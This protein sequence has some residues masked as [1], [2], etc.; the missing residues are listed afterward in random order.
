M[1][2]KEFVRNFSQLFGKPGSTR[3]QL[4][5]GSLGIAGVRFSNTLLAFLASVILAR[6]LGANDFGVYSFV[7]ALIMLLCVPI[8]QG[9]AKLIIR[10]TAT[11]DSNKNWNL[12]RGLWQWSTYTNL[13]Y[14]ILISIFILTFVWFL[15]NQINEK[16]T[17]TIMIALLLVPFINQISLK[18][19]ALM[20]LRKVAIGPFPDSVL[21]PGL[22]IFLILFVITILPHAELT[23]S[24]A[25]G[26]H[27]IAAS[28]A[29]VASAAILYRL[30][31]QPLVSHPKPVFKTNIWAK[32]AL[33]LALIAGLQVIN[34]CADII[35]LGLLR[36]SEEVGI[37]RVVAQSGLLITFVMQTIGMVAGPYIA[38]FYSQKDHHNLQKIITICTR[39]IFVIS[40]PIALVLSIWGSQVLG[41]LFGEGYIRGHTALIILST[42]LLLFNIIGPVGLLL[43]MTG[44][45]KQA[46]IRVAFTAILNIILNLVLIPKFGINGAALATVTS[47]IVSQIILRKFVSTQLGI[48][49]SL[50]SVSK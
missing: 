8:Q 1:N 19:S 37:Y 26:L 22:F 42:G 46:V 14:S 45:E 16:K 21:R 47:L 6:A 39:A 17:V 27:V 41:L 7:Y 40:F 32:A 43:E 35:M 28:L 29:L 30:Q 25:M 34:T 15:K 4:I 44:H 38:R 10:E 24:N 23:P 20:G 18:S 2:I 3:Y 11:A 5:S 12:M 50:L 49:C 36:T 33:P 9:V 48:E 13:V 31:P